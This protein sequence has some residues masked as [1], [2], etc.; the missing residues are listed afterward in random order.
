LLICGYNSRGREVL[1]AIEALNS[2][3]RALTHAQA[4]TR[5]LK[6]QGLL[7]PGQIVVGFDDGKVFFTST[8]ATPAR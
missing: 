6:S 2:R 5:Q 3:P 7:Q 4:L 1:A 8:S